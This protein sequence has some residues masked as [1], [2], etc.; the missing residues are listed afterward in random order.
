MDLSDDAGL[1]NLVVVSVFKEISPTN[2]NTEYTGVI[3]ALN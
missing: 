2:L 3:G 1:M